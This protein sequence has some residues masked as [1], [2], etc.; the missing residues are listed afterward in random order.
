MA[1]FGRQLL[2]QFEVLKTN[3]NAIHR[4]TAELLVS[5]FVQVTKL[6]LGYIAFDFVWIAI[7]PSTLPSLQGLI[8]FH[9]FVTFLLLTFPYRNPAFSHFTC[10]DGITEIN[11]FFL[12]AR[13][14][15]RNFHRAFHW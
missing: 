6:F 10:W 11:T 2:A 3:H 4:R 1:G 7:Q 12:I 13:R 5:H 9:H 15:T 14:Q 8:L